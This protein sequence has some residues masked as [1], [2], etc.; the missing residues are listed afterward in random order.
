MTHW[1]QRYPVGYS[2]LILAIG[3]CVGFAMLSAKPIVVWFRLALGPQ[4]FGM[5]TG[6][7]VLMIIVGSDWLWG[8]R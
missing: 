8:E 4:D 1:H 6:I 7:V 3:S 2:P 5:I